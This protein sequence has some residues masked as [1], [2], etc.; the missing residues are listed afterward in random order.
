M[1]KK[2][3]LENKLLKE[4][5]RILPTPQ[6]EYRFHETRRWRFDFAWPDKKVAV[7]VQGGVY[8]GGAHVRGPQYTKDREKMNTAQLD[9][10]IVLEVTTTHINNHDAIG[11]IEKAYHMR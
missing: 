3:D 2:K 4:I 1:A 11:W 7:E 9:G 10:W 5:V 6:R 8:T